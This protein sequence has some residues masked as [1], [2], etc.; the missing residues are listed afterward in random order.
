MNRAAAWI[1]GA[2][3]GASAAYFFDPDR[4]RRRRALLRD[5]F[6]SSTRRMQRECGR[7]WR[8]VM[9]R[10]EGY[11]H[12]AANGLRDQPVSDTTLAAR[13]RSRLGRCVSHP[14]AVAVSDFSYAFTF[15][16]AVLTATGVVLGAGGGG[17]TLVDGIQDRVDNGQSTAGV[18]EDTGVAFRTANRSYAPGTYELVRVTFQ[19][20]AGAAGPVTLNLRAQLTPQGSTTKVET[21]VGEP[22]DVCSMVEGEPTPDEVRR[23]TD[24]VM[25]KLIDLVEELRG[26]Q[27]PADSGVERVAD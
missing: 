18:G 25:A 19:A 14:A 2:L 1:C 22:I 26:E 23:L 20:A 16:P 13:V 17:F 8:D 11:L 9:N 21:K 15:D 24:V 7:T 4:G 10:T 5:R 6:R 3:T 27:A 12:E